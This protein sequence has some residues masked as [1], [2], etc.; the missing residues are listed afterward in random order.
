MEI[1]LQASFQKG[2]KGF[3]WL[4]YSNLMLLKK[5]FGLP[6]QILARELTCSPTVVSHGEGP[7]GQT[8]VYASRA[9]GTQG[10]GQL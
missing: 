10:P 2:F 4:G 1:H 8:K 3:W 6:W 5:A 9:L 7:W